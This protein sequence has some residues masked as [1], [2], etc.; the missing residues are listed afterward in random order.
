MKITI[1]NTTIFAAMFLSVSSCRKADLPTPTPTP[2]TKT[3]KV[4]FEFF[5]KVGGNN[6]SL[7]G[8]WYKNENGDSFQLT[9]FNYY[10]SNIKFNNVDGSSFSE[11]E[12]Y[13][14]V[15]QETKSSLTFE[16]S[17]IPSG[18]YSSVTY[19]IG[20]DS[21]R[22]VSGAQ[23]GDLD[24]AKGMFWSWSTG[25]IMLKIEGISPKSTQAGN[26]F[27]LHAGGFKGD[28]N[29]L[30]T[31]TLTF[32]NNIVVNGDENHLHINADVQKALGSPNPVD[33][34][35]TNVIMSAGP[36]GKALANNYQNMFSIS[37]AGK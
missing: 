22:N 14:L 32:P 8:D 36:S 34:S 4:M 23:T 35:K 5:N 31:I 33:F 25:Y 28:Y 7:S 2:E 27:M 18:T 19:T 21:L 12:S 24:P 10:I 37:Y 11:P 1:I 6:I 17:N 15:E 3:G 26:I 20:V 13:H 16:V 29:V 30:R 9:K